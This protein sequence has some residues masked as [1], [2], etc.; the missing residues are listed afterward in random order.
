M[1]SISE[2]RPV[3]AAHRVP[4]RR[5]REGRV[6]VDLV[7][8]DGGYHGQQQRPGLVVG[9]DQSHLEGLRAG[10]RHLSAADRI[11]DPMYSYVTFAIIDE[12]AVTNNN[13][14]SYTYIS[15]LF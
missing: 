1:Y 12:C 3:P 9:A 14:R 6:A 13:V 10:D 5:R 8:D 2:P 7:H 15:L 11:P 4:G